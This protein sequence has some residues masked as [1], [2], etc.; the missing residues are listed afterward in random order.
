[1]VILYLEVLFFHLIPILA[2]YTFH[3]V[4]GKPCPAEFEVKVIEKEIEE[5][6]S[7]IVKLKERIQK[8]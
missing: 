6:K 4:D 2:I 5:E 3:I 1:M 7:R 8:E